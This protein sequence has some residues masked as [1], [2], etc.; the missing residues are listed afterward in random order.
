MTYVVPQTLEFLRHGTGAPL[1]RLLT[2]PENAVAVNAVSAVVVAVCVG[3]VVR[4]LVFWYEQFEGPADANAD[5]PLPHAPVSPFLAALAFLVVPQ[6]ARALTVLSPFLFSLA[7]VALSA[8]VTASLNSRPR[9]PEEDEMDEAE[10][11]VRPWVLPRLALA[12]AF[13][14]VGVWEGPCGL[15]AAPFLLAITC[16]PFVRRERSAM[17]V[18]LVWTVGFVFA[19]LTEPLVLPG[20]RVQALVP[21]ALPPLFGFAIFAFV[22][23]MP[24]AVVRRFGENRWTLGG[25][26]MTLAVFAVLSLTSVPFGR[27][28]ASERF[29]RSVLGELGER[30]YIL[31]DGIFD[32]MIDEFKPEGVTRLGM[33]T[34]AEREFLLT[35]FGEGPITNRVLAVRGCYGRFPD[36]EAVAA[37]VG[38]R[39]CA[40]RDARLETA[41]TVRLRSCAE[42]LRLALRSM[43]DFRDLPAARAKAEE[44]VRQ[45]IRQGWRDGLAGLGMSS[46]LL[47][48][49]MA[50]GDLRALE[51]DAIS[52]LL[53]N[54]ED[55]A[56]NAALGSLRFAEGRND[57]AERYL[58]K[59][60]KGGGILAMRDYARLLISLDRPA[61]ALDWARK[62]AAKAPCDCEVRMTLAAALIETGNFKA[63][64]TELG[65]VQRL[66]S[67]QHAATNVTAFVDSARRRLREKEKKTDSAGALV[68]PRQTSF[69]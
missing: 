62:A 24:L 13:A 52:A 49:D 54:P 23:A 17:S 42:E 28:S 65:E 60:V 29:V 58:E 64:R 4:R 59:G 6:F 57:L 37:E 66:A 30:R 61:E 44:T 43:E 47:A 35:E 1:W 18:C 36:M 26:G 5:R 38:G 51:A 56:A 25:W 11:D 27:T 39:F 10:R 67:E 15:A 20:C 22:S 63:A 32:T 31:G 40:G 14:A 2:S 34:V 19:F 69:H 8:A 21:Y 55:P 50:A 45:S 3:F 46:T 68:S 48:L 7:P 9:P 53:M 16:L 41:R 33:T 12:G